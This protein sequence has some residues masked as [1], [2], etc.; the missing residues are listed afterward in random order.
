VFHEGRVYCT[1]GQDPMHGRGRGLL[2]CIDAGQTGDITRS[3]CEWIYDGIERTIASVAVNDGLIYASD[4]AGRVHCLDEKTGRALWV[5][6]TKA[7]DWSTPL[8]ADG[9]VYINTNKKLVTL[10]A[11]RKL[12]V[13]S[14]V[15]LGSS[16]YAT[17]VAADGTLFVCSQSYLWAV[18][19]GAR[20]APVETAAE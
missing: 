9:K 20:T 12:M 2:H 14:E 8:V 1:I 15:S 3:G 7:E 4:L 11:G 6:E 17:P 5:Y 16:G 13:L 19:Q 18:Q 10:A